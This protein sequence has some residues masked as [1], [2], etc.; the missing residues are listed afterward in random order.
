MLKFFI[1]DVKFAKLLQKN[2]K[3]YNRYGYGL[4][5]YRMTLVAV[6]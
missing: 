6:T 1:S 4:K 5:S 3:E 2:Q